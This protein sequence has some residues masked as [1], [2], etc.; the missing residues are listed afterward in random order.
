MYNSKKEAQNKLEHIIILLQTTNK[1]SITLNTFKNT[2]IKWKKE[3]LNYFDN[4][5][6][7]GFTEGCYTK[8]KL[9]KRISYGFRNVYTYI[10]K[11]KLSFMSN[12]EIYFHKI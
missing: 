3:I 4:Y 2:I 1:Y 10:A 5:T 8:I 11:M 7:N 6:T 9:I 12:E